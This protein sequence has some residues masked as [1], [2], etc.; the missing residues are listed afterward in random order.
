MGARSFNEITG[1]RRLDELNEK[2][3]KFSVRTLKE[4]CL[5][6]PEKIYIKRSV[7]LTAEQTKLYAQMNEVCLGSVRRGPA[8]NY[9]QCTYTDYETATDML[10]ISYE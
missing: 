9:S 10:W 5:D 8:G 4:D 7:P 6:L 3:N 1:Y 2:L